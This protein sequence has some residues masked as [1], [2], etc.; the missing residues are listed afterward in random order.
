MSAD[1]RTVR[2]NPRRLTSPSSNCTT[3]LTSRLNTTP[4]YH[5]FAGHAGESTHSISLCVRTWVHSANITQGRPNHV[6]SSPP[7]WRTL[8]PLLAAPSHRCT[9]L[10]QVAVPRAAFA[11]PLDGTSSGPLPVGVALGNAL[12]VGGACLRSLRCECTASSMCF[13]RRSVPVVHQSGGLHPRLDRTALSAFDNPRPPT[14][15]RWHG[16]ETSSGA[17]AR[18]ASL[19]E[20]S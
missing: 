8:A 5:C 10:E 13:R 9:C 19:F 3:Y 7:T 2:S 1:R 16:F 18:D 11:V 12:L 4:K 17:S 20:K 15:T 6:P 14:W